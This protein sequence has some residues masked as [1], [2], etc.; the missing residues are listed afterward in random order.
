MDLTGIKGTSPKSPKRVKQNG[1]N[2]FKIRYICQ[3]H[4]TELNGE[5]NFSIQVLSS[6][7][8]TTALVDILSAI[9]LTHMLPHLFL[10]DI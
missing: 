4:W 1:K 3:S 10:I 6:T 7:I 2:K 8:L 5:S 9:S